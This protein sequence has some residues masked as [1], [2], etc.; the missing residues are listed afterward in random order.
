LT[1][2]QS[3][4][5][6][7][8]V[9]EP[10]TPSGRSVLRRV[11]IFVLPFCASLAL[12]LLLQSWSGSHS[13]E[14]SGYPDEPAH[15]VTGLM[16]RGYLVQGWHRSWPMR[17]AEDF[18]LHYPK[19]A[20][21]HWPPF[22]YLLQFLWTIVFPTSISSILY[23]QAAT[24]A[25]TSA[26]LFM[27]ARSRYGVPTA[28]VLCGAFLVLGPTQMLASQVMSE[29][30]LVLSTVLATWTIARYFETGRLAWLLAFAASVVV[31]VHTKGS[32]LLLAGVPLV[33]P[34]LL[35]SPRELRRRSFVVV[36]GVMFLL[37]VPW[38][39]ATMKM[40]NNGMLGGI[41]A[42]EIIAQLREF[43]PIFGKVFGWPLIAA[44]AIGGWLAVFGRNERDP[45]LV[46]CAATAALT[47]VFHSILPSG[48][49][50]R[51]LFMA[52]PGML[53]LAPVPLREWLPSAPW[54]W[55][56]GAMLALVLVSMGPSFG[57]YHKAPVGY[58]AVAEW[59]V[60]NSW[61]EPEAILIASDADGEG[62]LISEIAQRQ[63]T[64]TLYLVRSSKLFEN[65]DWLGTD[66]QITVEN[67]TGAE[68][69]M[70]QTPI[71]YVV[72]D[73]L[74]S[75]GGDRA[76]ELLS[77]SVVSRPDLWELRKVQPANAATGGAGEIRIYQR[78]ALSATGQ[79]RV[80]VNLTRM[81]GR[82]IGE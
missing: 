7:C 46:S 2:K 18:Y 60:G 11:G 74:H 51:R 27:M 42:R 45:L 30:L 35:R 3:Q 15:Y 24:I 78:R 29:G 4:I 12:L 37:L 9:S 65:C 43:V 13:A 20:L 23:L 61:R 8:L 64:P 53:M 75:K 36:V 54:K 56:P 44:I 66:C 10:H 39:L 5:V 33:M 58:R 68:Q 72:M 73:T 80:R 77:E 70:D 17:Y 32:G 79:V 81:L 1:D 19:V 50:D 21:G 41:N 40:V 28:I 63:P 25:A 22:Y 16:V 59:L 38:Q 62:M 49:E 57:V 52:I 26:I 47:Y 14:L 76:T 34:F 55:V 31:A 6:E 69:V 67:P 71:R 48:M 82:V